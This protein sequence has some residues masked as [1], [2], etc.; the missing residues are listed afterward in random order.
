[1]NRSDPTRR[2]VRGARALLAGACLLSAGVAAP[3]RSA[4]ALRAGAAQVDIT[5]A[6]GLEMYGFFNRITEH[7]VASGTLDPLFARVLV[8]QAGDRRLALV[9]LDLGRT[10]NEAWLE[11][12]RAA[13]RDDSRV[14]AVIVAASH[15]HSGPNI[16]DVYPDGRPPPWE[17]EALEKVTRA[18]HQAAAALEP[19]RIG[20]GYGNAFIGYNRRQV[21]PAGHVTMRWRNPEKVANGPVDSTV[22]V[23]RVDRGDGTPIAILVNYAC[24]PTVLG[25]DNLR[26]SADFIG[27]M[28]A[29]IAASF[30]GK[31][32]CFFLQ[33]AAGDINPYFDGT[34][35]DQGA[36]EKRDWTGHELGAEAA[37]VARGI[38]PADAA[39]ASID[40][41][42]DVMVFPW[43]WE[44]RKFRE[45]LLRVDGPLVFQDHA[46]VLAAASPP[47]ELSLHVTTLLINRQI[48][49]IGMPGEPFVDFQESWRDRC[50][51]RACFF[52]G[53]ANGYYDYFP[54]IVAA[55]QGGYGA[56]DSNTYVAV[57]AGERMLD[58]ALIRMHR[59][60][61]QL[62]GVPL[63]SPG[64]PPIH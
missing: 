37:R 16:L 64:A 24:H 23:I 41:A 12:L 63:N 32:V 3:A 28:A 33:G 35:L 50:P 26:Y 58:H 52:L 31:P 7:R 49:I 40:F 10:F 59:M 8:L 56:G 55:T 27:P 51:V 39:A 13:V 19:A 46:D 5:P 15:T 53:Y 43:R 2:S 38:T 30:G 60:L 54:T 1:M 4:E 48:G 45:D 62:S 21:D 57:G 11:R 6:P 42:D 17:D 29:T 22:G 20:T 47:A 36:V 25:S 44:P 34:P 9:T 61:G 14:D 18:V